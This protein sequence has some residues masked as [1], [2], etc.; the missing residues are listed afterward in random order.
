MSA[1]GHAVSKVFKS[2][3]SFVKKYWKPIVAAVAI[4]FTAGAALAYFAPAEAAAGGAAAVGAEAAGTAAAEGGAA[5]LGAGAAE[6]GAAALGAGA[7]AGAAEASPW[8]AGSIAAETGGAAGLAGGA[9]AGAAASSEGLMGGVG[10]LSSLGG[11]AA[12]GAGAAGAAAGASPYAFAGP[13]MTGPP[14]SLAGSVGAPSSLWQTS[15]GV[16]KTAMSTPGVPSL[17]G[18]LLNSY[19]QGQMLN[20]Q[21]KYAEQHAPGQIA[22]GAANAWGGFAQNKN[23]TPTTPLPAKSS[24]PPLTPYTL[25]PNQAGVPTMPGVNQPGSNSSRYLGYGTPGYGQQFPP[26]TQPIYP[27]GQMPQDLAQ[28]QGLQQQGLLS[29]Q[30]PFIESPYDESYV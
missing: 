5:A 20:A 28:Q 25:P 30:T 11:D 13:E 14:A 4:Y 6:G 27:T 16:A 29:Q 21:M 12:A 17:I 8:L 15:L 24:L 2:V 19:S 22:G 1:I 23:L 7:A 10:M 18:G 3:G 26:G 9:A